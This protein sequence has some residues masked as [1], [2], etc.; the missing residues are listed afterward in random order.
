MDLKKLIGKTITDVHGD[1]GG[2]G[3]YGYHSHIFC[4]RDVV[5]GVVREVDDKWM[6]IEYQIKLGEDVED[7]GIKGGYQCMAIAVDKICYLQIEGK[8]GE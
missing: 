1:V 8:W 3:N 2:G 4:G 5:G 7:L 6:I